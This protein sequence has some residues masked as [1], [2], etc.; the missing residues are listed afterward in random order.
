MERSTWIDLSIIFIRTLFRSGDCQV[1]EMATEQHVETDRDR[2]RDRGI[3]RHKYRRWI[4]ASPKK[5]E[6]ARGWEK[7]IIFFRWSITGKK[8]LNRY[9]VW[10]DRWALKRSDSLRY[11]TSIDLF[12]FLRII[13]YWSI[14]AGSA[15]DSGK[16]YYVWIFPAVT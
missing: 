2:Q 7:K 3:F 8:E 1:T 13:G 15:R 4:T 16:F 14:L 6:T 10:P 5:I 11:Y 9:R 12:F